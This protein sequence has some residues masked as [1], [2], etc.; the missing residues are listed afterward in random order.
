MAT[1]EFG[2]IS[3]DM[4]LTDDAYGIAVL[5]NFDTF[6]LNF[7]EVRE[8][9]LVNTPNLVVIRL[10]DAGGAFV[11]A[12]V[13]GN[14]AANQVSSVAIDAIG[15]VETVSGNFTVDDLGTVT[16]TAT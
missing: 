9:I 10:F 5:R 4:R 16:G 12:S 2:N 13:Q 11:T 1:V 3:A 14:L 7:L 15:I 8:E 6:M